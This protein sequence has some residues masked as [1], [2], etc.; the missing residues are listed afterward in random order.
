[1]MPGL[2]VNSAMW[3]NGA[4]VPKI[5]WGA[6]Q[7][8]VALWTLWGSLSTAR[9]EG[10]TPRST[11]MLAIAAL[12]LT[13]YYFNYDMVAVAGAAVIYIGARERLSIGA[14]VLFGLLWAMPLLMFELKL[15]RLPL[16]SFILPAVFLY[17]SLFDRQAAAMAPPVSKTE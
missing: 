11:L 9:R 12:M 14:F 1:M 5:F 15:A 16:P 4:M 6:F 3:P 17:L 13:P 8:A 2:Y 7:A 10:I